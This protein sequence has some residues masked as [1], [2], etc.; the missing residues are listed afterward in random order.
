MTQPDAPVFEE[1]WHAQVMAM[2][3]T[4]IKSGHVDA[5]VWA[6]TLGAALRLAHDGGAPD[7]TETYYMCVLQALEQMTEPH[8]SAE[9]RQ[10]RRADWEAAYHRTP[11]GEPVTLE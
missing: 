6:E 1:P 5:G 11:H 3:D 10:V 7:N 2:A 4:L 8:I 9:D